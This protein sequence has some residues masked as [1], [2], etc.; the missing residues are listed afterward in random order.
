ME[1]RIAIAKFINGDKIAH[2]E[3]IWQYDYGQEL[4]LEGL[5]LPSAFE[6]H[7]AKELHGNAVTSLY[8]S[9]SALIPDQLIQTPGTLF[10]W[11]YLHDTESDGETEYTIVIDVKKRAKP[12]HETPTP[13]QQSEIEQLIA[14]LETAV[15]ESET[16]VTHYP[17]IEDGY[18]Y[19]WDAVENDW[20]NTGVEATG[21]QG[22]QGPQGPEGQ[23]GPQGPEGPEGPAGADGQDGYSPSA[24]VSKSGATATITITDK[25]GTTT[26]SI[27]DG[28]ALIDD[29]TT[30]QDSTWSSSKIDN[31]KMDKNN[32]TGSG[33]LSINRLAGSQVG[34]YSAAEG[35]WCE[36]EGSR[37]HAE[38]YRTAANGDSSHSEGYVTRASGQYSHAQNFETIAAS[39]CQSASG[40]Y[41]IPDY[42]DEYAEI[43]GNG[44]GADAR[45]NARTLDWNGNEKLA[46]KLTV[47]ADPTAAMDVVPKA[48]ME[49]AIQ[50]AVLSILPKKTVSGAVASFSDAQAGYPLIDL[51]AQIV[52][53]QSGTGD[54]SPS[55]VRPISGWTGA[56]V[57][58]SGKNLLKQPY[59]LPADTYDSVALSYDSDFVIHLTGTGGSSAERFLTD[60]FTLPEGTYKLT[61]AQS[62]DRTRVYFY[63]NG[64]YISRLNTDLPYTFTSA[65]GDIFKISLLIL[66]SAY[67]DAT[68]KLMI[69]LGS[70]ATAYEPY[71]GTAYSVTWQ[72]EAGTVYVGSIDLITGVLTVTHAI[73][74]FNGTEAWTCTQDGNG[75]TRVL[76]NMTSYNPY[77]EGVG[78]VDIISNIIRP[79]TSS[80]DL[81]YPP[82]N[83]GGINGNAYLIVGV[84]PTTITSADDWKTLLS[85]TNMQLAYP[86][87]TPQTYQL[88]P[89][90]VNTLLG[91]N[92]IFADTGNSLVT[93]GAKIT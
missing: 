46:G 74:T 10:A 25:N 36:A 91:V 68:V 31:T 33:A 21:P 8:N 55:N 92:N 49:Q 75:H 24:S 37:S 62:A 35:Y 30:A 77:H 19:V 14:T 47:G 17:K 79:S 57:V 23:E 32:P 6:V 60:E 66:S 52:P 78:T 16:N 61:T 90:E 65:K 63:K 15:E 69:E 81:Y 27:S 3:S 71:N 22:E 56:N 76:L 26:A 72:T 83:R 89:T 93:Y 73:V 87:A 53:K 64:T 58:R 42:D 51:T 43:V 28:A 48:F 59:I 2:T 11:V 45:S 20:S 84:D 40:K 7:F 18:W 5:D 80:Q 4:K 9:G 41:N 44:T 39:A 34:N 88:T 50:D 1:N 86:L 67:S 13:A 12:S 82:V 54:P 85:G 70:T 38:G 29:T